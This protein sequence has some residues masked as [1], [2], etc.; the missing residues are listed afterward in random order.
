MGITTEAFQRLI[1]FF[2][3]E[4]GVNRIESMHDPN[5]PASGKVMQHCGLV[6]EGTL[7]QADRNNQGLCDAAYYGLLREDYD[8]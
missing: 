6:Y 1:P 2:F 4:V 3:D 7:R 5:N 8:K